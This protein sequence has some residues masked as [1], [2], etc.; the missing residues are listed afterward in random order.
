MSFVTV[1]TVTTMAF[2]LAV[3]ALMILALATVSPLRRSVASTVHDARDAFSDHD[4]SS[5]SQRQPFA[6]A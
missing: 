6:A 5:T 4:H 3:P 2:V 1:F